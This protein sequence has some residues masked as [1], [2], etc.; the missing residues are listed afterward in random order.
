MGL[1]H[2]LE[3]SGWAK[4]IGQEC[5]LELHYM[6]TEP[7]RLPLHTKLAEY[8]DILYNEKYQDDV[9]VISWIL[10]KHAKRE[11]KDVLDL[12]CGT[13]SHL[14]LL[15][16][17][18]YNVVGVDASKEMVEVAKMKLIGLNKE[19]LIRYGDV[20]ELDINDKFD[21]VYCWF[22]SIQYFFQNEELGRVLSN[23]HR[24]L[25]EDGL[26]LVDMRNGSDFLS[27]VKQRMPISRKVEKDG[28]DVISTTKNVEF[29]EHNKIATFHSEFIVNDKGNKF[30]V[31]E[32]HSYRLLG[33]DEFSS[34]L[35]NSG[36]II[37]NIYGSSTEINVP[38][39][40]QSDKMVFVASKG[41]C[42]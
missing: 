11:T 30:E 35:R 33:K 14:L 25:R 23:V 38:F 10:K 13:G 27:R 29:E 18:G 9:D 12:M 42:E 7:F 8:Y 5:M 16:E 6:F 37:E 21:A 39:N 20:R 15:L 34:F 24:V 41:K 28:I 40:K 4:G 36:F 26:F 22:N 17:R 31:K 19:D 32:S 3:E 2:P 1:S